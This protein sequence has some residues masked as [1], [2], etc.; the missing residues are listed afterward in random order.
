MLRTQASSAFGE[1]PLTDPRSVGSSV[2]FHGFL[3][4]LLGWLAVFERRGAGR[5][6]E[7]AADP[8]ASSSRWTT[9][10]I[11]RRYPGREAGVRVRSAGS[12]RFR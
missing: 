8:R 2:L 1:T 7:L 10:P 5:R 4:L 12:T 3:V 11:G 9:G 6:A